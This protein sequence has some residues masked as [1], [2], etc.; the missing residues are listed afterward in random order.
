MSDATRYLAAVQGLYFLIT[1]IWPL[2]SIRTFEAVTGPKTDD[3][4]VKTVGVLIVVMGA[5][6][7]LAAYR[8]QVTPETVALA[9]GGALALAGVDV[10][11]VGRRVIPRIYLA[12]AAAELILIASWAAA[13]AFRG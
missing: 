12:D 3:W 5:V 9:V 1:G 2:V 13:W 11:Y 8:G 7:L 4:L 6:L 10:W